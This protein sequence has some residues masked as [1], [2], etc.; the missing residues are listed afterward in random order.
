MQLIIDQECIFN[1]VG[2][3]CFTL[4]PSSNALVN[5]INFAGKN[6]LN[7]RP[8]LPDVSS[9]CACAD[10]I[11]SQIDSLDLSQTYIQYAGVSDIPFIFLAVNKLKEKGMQLNDIGLWHNFREPYSKLNGWH[12]LEEGKRDDSNAKFIECTT[13]TALQK[14][15]GDCE[16][17]VITFA[18]SSKIY[19]ED[20][21]GMPVERYSTHMFEAKQIHRD[22]IMNKKVAIWYA[23]RLKAS[24]MSLKCDEVHLALAV[25][26]PMAFCIAYI[27]LEHTYLPRIVIYHYEKQNRVK[28][29]WGIEFS[30]SGYK[31]TQSS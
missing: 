3:Q 29:P 5:I 9:L 21:I 14:P 15:A 28:R 24:I 8:R 13:H 25:S 11:C 20:L 19:Y 7:G 23:E 27:L 16:R 12:L 4:H 6:V 30:A 17:R 22:A 26:V 10:E 1:S 2:K 31:I 18:S